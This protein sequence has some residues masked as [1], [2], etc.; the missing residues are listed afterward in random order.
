M[1][2][3]NEELIMALVVDE[4]SFEEFEIKYEYSLEY[5]TLINLL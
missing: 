4:I 2:N 3:Y 1:C 5:N